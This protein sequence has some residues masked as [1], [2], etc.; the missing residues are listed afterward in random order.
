MR[1]KFCV[2]EARQQH[3]NMVTRLIGPFSA[4][5]WNPEETGLNREVSKILK[6]FVD[7][8]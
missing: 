4:C 5:L 1:A 2:D 3:D 7:V 6:G 8:L